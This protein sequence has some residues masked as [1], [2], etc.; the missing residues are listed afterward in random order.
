MSTAATQGALY[1][2]VAALN[3]KFFDAVNQ[4]DMKTVNSLWADD[5]E[6]YHARPG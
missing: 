2:T 4:C 6:F 3:T 1:Q 5:A